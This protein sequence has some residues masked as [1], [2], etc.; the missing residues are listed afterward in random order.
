MSPAKKRARVTPAQL[1]AEAERARL[2]AYAP[3]SRFKVGAALLT[4][5]G[6]IVRGCN[7]ENASYGLSICAERNAVFRAVGQGDRDFVAVAVTAGKGQEASPCGSCRQVLHEFAPAMRVYWRDRRGRIIGRP[8][9]SL[10]ARP[11]R[12]A[13]ARKP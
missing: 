3:Y 13:R 9:E 11:F 10:L 2:Q 5:D 4:C 1:M 8:I 7:V 12:F 6:K